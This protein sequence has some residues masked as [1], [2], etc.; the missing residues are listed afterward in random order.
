MSLRVYLFVGVVM[1]VAAALMALHFPN[2]LSTRWGHYLA[3]IAVCVLS[4]WLWVSTSS[5]EGKITMA[6]SAGLASVMLWGAGPAMIIALLSTAIADTFIH[7]KQSIRVG[8]NAAQSA[9]TTWLT[10][11][12]FVG[13]GGP[14][15]GFAAVP[16]ASATGL[17]SLRLLLPVVGAFVAYFL[18]NRIQVAAAVAL[19]TERNYFEVLRKDYLYRER[20]VQDLAA[21]LLSPLMVIAFRSVDYPG[22]AL[23]FAPLGLLNESARRYIA[24]QQ[25]QDQMI[26]TERM[27]AKGE[28]AAGIGHELRNMLAT[29]NGRAQFVVQKIDRQMHD[30]ARKDAQVILEAGERMLRLSNNLMQFSGNEIKLERI[31]VNAL[32]QR[33]SE[34]VRSQNKFDDIEWEFD[35]AN[36]LPELRADYGQLQQVLVNLF[37]NAADAMRDHG[38]NNGASRKLIAV[39]SSRLEKTGEIQIVVHDSG[40]GI[41]DSN[42][43]KIFEPHFTTKSDGNGFGLSTSFRIISSHKGRIVVESPPGQGARFTITLPVGRN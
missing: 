12:A 9:V 37:M 32:L 42:L 22:V 10:A 11:F 38:K 16:P 39:Q 43:A 30:G 2:D 5:G 1:I 25:A 4:E 17:D 34:F 19:S 27:A 18:G 35:L 31:D 40:C 20:L 15:A 23:F 21:F 13:L 41:P 24:L 28:M 36:P 3:W 14:A 26:R 6:S 7:R 8:F 33:T 29:I